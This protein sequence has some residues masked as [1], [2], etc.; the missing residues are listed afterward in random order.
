MLS[1]VGRLAGPQGLTGRSLKY[2]G[3]ILSVLRLFSGAFTPILFGNVFGGLTLKGRFFFDCCNLCDGERKL[4]SPPL[5]ASFAPA[6]NLVAQT[7]MR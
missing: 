6:E 1:F 3:L 2:T 4:K 5:P 7:L